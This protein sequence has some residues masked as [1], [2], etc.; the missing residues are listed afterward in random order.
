LFR[1]KEGKWSVFVIR[2]NAA[3]QLIIEVGLMNDELVEVLSENITTE[4]SVV[5]APETNLEDG[6]RVTPNEKLPTE[7][8]VP[9][10]GD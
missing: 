5:L 2:S 3:K 8:Q 9:V 7:A 10:H 4:D 1:N 6:T